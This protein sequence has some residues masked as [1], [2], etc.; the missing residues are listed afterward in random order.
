M[1]PTCSL[2]LPPHRPPSVAPHTIHPPVVKDPAGPETVPKI[3]LDLQVSFIFRC[4]RFPMFLATETGEIAE[5]RSGQERGG[6]VP[7]IHVF[8]ARIQVSRWLCQGHWEQ[9]PRAAPTQMGGGQRTHRPRGRLAL[10]PH[11]SPALGS[12][13]WAGIH[14]TSGQPASS[15]Y[16][17]ITRPKGRLSFE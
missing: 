10:A 15:P 12:Q 6:F 14:R 7:R 3:F 16:P 17:W 4:L 2:D 5:A 11:P 9:V 1:L 13:L 8:P